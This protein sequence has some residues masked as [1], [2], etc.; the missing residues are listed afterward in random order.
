MRDGERTARQYDAMADAYEADT[1]E[2]PF[3]AYYERP[4]M[5]TLV[6]EVEGRRVLELGCGT[7]PLTEWLVGGGAKVTACDV[8]PTM[9]DKARRRLG[10]RARLLVADIAQPLP[11]PSASFDLV[12]ASLVLHYVEDWAAVLAEMHR[13]LELSGAVVFSTHHP[14]MDWQLA[15]PED[16]FATKQV[17]ET[18]EKGGE[19]HEV[20]FWRRPLTAM[21]EAISGA[22]FVIERIVEPRPLPELAERDPAAYDELCTLPRFLFFRLRPAAS[23]STGEW[24]VTAREGPS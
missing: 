5:T 20:T 21:C 3:N 12:V 14:T 6:G 16:Y 19:P 15:S 2:G 13:V 4:A 22:G 10:D 9:V 24:A 17:T 18:W 7:G 8:S 11:F 1:A 23:T